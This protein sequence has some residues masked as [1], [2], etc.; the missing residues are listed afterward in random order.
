MQIIFYIYSKILKLF[1]KSKVN[2]LKKMN[3]NFVYICFAKVFLRVCDKKLKSYLK[4]NLN[5]VF[6][7]LIRKTKFLMFYILGQTID[8]IVRI[9]VS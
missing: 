5:Q 9:L 8:F 6:F 3:K 7:L 1:T 4:K 2:T